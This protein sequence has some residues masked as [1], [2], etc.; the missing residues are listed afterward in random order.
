MMAAVDG[1]LAHKNTRGET[2]GIEHL[3][4][5]FLPGYAQS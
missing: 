3:T 4:L 2:L 1:V 5:H